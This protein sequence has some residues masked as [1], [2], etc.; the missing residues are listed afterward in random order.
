MTMPRAKDDATAGTGRVPVERKRRR[1][2]RSGAVLSAESIVE[3]ALTLVDE[4]GADALTMRKLG[5]ALGADPSAVYRYFR[6]VED[7]HLALGDRLIGETMS[8]FTPD[9]AD[10][11]SS[12]RDFGIRAYRSAQRHPRAALLSGFRVTR[13]PNEQ[14]A[15][16]TGIGLLRAAGFGPRDAVRHYHVFV[17]TV[18]GHAALDAAVQGLRPEQRE[19][20]EGAWADV[21]ADLSPSTHPHLH[22]ARAHLPL[23]RDSAFERA[24]DLLLT[25]IASAP[26]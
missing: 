13:L 21:Y 18:L 12:L 25:A 9:P 2:T 1:P 20:D 23:M 5:Q 7:L 15:I 17:D 16:D 19:A 8:G 14:R 11:Q 26:R 24:L 10:W 6:S 22:E 3:K 4:H